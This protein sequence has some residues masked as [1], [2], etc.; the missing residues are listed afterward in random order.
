MRTLILDPPSAGLEELLDRRRRAEADRSDEVWEGVYHMVPAPS[1]EHADIEA[2]LLA[3]L[4]APAAAAEL[5]VTGQFNLGESDHDYRVPDGGLHRH[6]PRG[7]WHQTAAL[8]AEIV[9]PGDET[10]EKLRFYAVHQVDELLI[11]D[12][13]ERSVS[14]LALEEGE[15]RPIE[16]SQLIALGT[17]EL[18]ELIDWPETESR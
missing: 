3:L 8:V 6:R 10:W 12:P 17:G 16:H 11:V 1:G 2:Q 5:T 18:H 7:V 15:Y 4:R 13:Q 14:W 9:S